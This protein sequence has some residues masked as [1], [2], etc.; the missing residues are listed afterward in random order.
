MESFRDRVV[1]VTGASSGIG[2]ATACAFARE[3]AHVHLVDID[4][5]G[6]AA[7]LESVRRLGARGEFH[8]ADCTSFEEISELSQRIF[9][10]EHRVHVLMNNAGIGHSSSFDSLKIEDWRRVL[11]INL[12]GVIHGVQ[13]FVPRMLEQGAPAHVVNTSSGLGLFAVPTLGPYV[14]SKYAVVGLTESLHME[15]APRGITFTALCPGIIDTDIVRRAQI[16]GD[17]KPLHQKAVDFYRNRGASPDRVAADV[18]KAIRK[19]RLIQ[20]SPESQV[21]PGWLLRRVTASGFAKLTGLGLMRVL[22]KGARG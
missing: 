1:V 4:E 13:A 22:E 21:L 2:R 19:K 6:G 17:A 20:P 5:E 16:G 18:L 3:G 12:Y 11:D 15:L 8:R 9:D 10:V 14:A 7:A